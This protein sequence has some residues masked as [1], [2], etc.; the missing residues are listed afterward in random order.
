MTARSPKSWLELQVRRLAAA[1][2]RAR[3][4]EERLEELD[5]LDEARVEGVAVGRGK[6]EE[7]VPVG[8]FDV[9]VRGLRLHVDGLVPHL[10][11]ALGR[12]HLHAQR[13]ARAVLR[14]DLERIARLPEL[15]PAGGDGLE[16]WWRSLEC[17]RLVDFG[18]D[19][20]VRT[21]QHALAALDAE[22]LVP[23]RDLLG[24]VALLPPR[25]SRRIDPV[26]RNRAH[27]ERVALAGEDGA[28]H[29]SHELGRALGYGRPHRDLAGGLRGDGHLVQMGQGAIDRLPVLSHHG[30]AALA[31]AV[32]D[33]VLDGRDRF[34]TRQDTAQREEAGLHDGVDTPA[35]ARF[36]GYAVAVDDEEAE[37]PGDQLLLQPARELVPHLVGAVGAVE[38]ERGARLRRLEHVDALE[39]GELV[40]GHEGRTLDE[41]GRADRP[42]SVA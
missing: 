31:V 40:T 18:P 6:P 9:V 38:E 30:L 27:R 41:V 39:E 28:R 14:R 7:E 19:D 5:V 26:G 4:L 21:D 3:E 25:R 24:D 15:P 22:R 1:G 10:A 35:H 36:P 17:R 23:H 12:T 32:S 20:G 11:L 2:A 16:P 33:G 34:V 13:A 8:D 29:A 37:P 42:R